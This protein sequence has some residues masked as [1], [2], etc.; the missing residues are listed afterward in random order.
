[1]FAFNTVLGQAAH[2]FHSADIS[3]LMPEG[4]ATALTTLLAEA[5]VNPCDLS[6]LTIDDILARL[7]EAG[8]DASAI[9]GGSV[10]EGLQALRGR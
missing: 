4:E 5:G 2:L 8:V 1:M 10:V 6:G 9:D 7:T 3:E